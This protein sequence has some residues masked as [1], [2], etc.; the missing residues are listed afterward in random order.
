MLINAANMYR[1]LHYMKQPLITQLPAPI[2]KP[3][4]PY[5]PKCDANFKVQPI[6]D[7]FS[8]SLSQNTDISE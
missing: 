2:V 1:E 6:L 7:I 8:Q 3:V 4:E 5:V